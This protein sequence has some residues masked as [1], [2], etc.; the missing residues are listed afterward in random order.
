MF[1]F[2][3]VHSKKRKA[4][5]PDGCSIVN[6]GVRVFHKQFLIRCELCV[7]RPS[8][9]HTPRKVENQFILLFCLSLTRLCEN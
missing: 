9:S 6:I 4:D 5:L 2:S 7:N 8:D 3:S 1:L